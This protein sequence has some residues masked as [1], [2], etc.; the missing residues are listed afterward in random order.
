MYLKKISL[1]QFEYPNIFQKKLSVFHD[2]NFLKLYIPFIN[3]IGIFNQNDELTGL[4]YY[5]KK[6]RYFFKFIIPP[7]FQPFN[8]LIYFT[9][10]LKAES[11]NSAIKELHQKIIQYFT[12]TEKANYI[13]FVLSP[14][15]IDTQ[16]Y[17]WKKWQV[18]VNYTYRLNLE[19]SINGLFENISSEKR[20]SIRK[21]EKDGIKVVEEKNYEV[22][23]N[24]IIKTFERQKKKINVIY[25]NKILNEWA[26]ENN[27]FAYVAY[28]NEK[29]IATTFCVFDNP[30]A[31]YLFG[32]YDEHASHHG[33]GVSCMWQSI[34]KTKEMGLKTFDFEGSMLP[35]VERYFRDFGG[36]LIPYYSCEKWQ[37]F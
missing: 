9:N 32:G 19:G 10:S 7:P 21:A 29:A 37:L 27:S 20:K 13:R 15:F 25:L 33:G 8:G 24:L 30:T 2:I 34:L 16:E 28:W 1:E 4:F 23:K 26:N 17:I 14:E 18:K 35:S 22:V 5:F 11:K 31:Y 3:F 12:K 36:Q 6:S